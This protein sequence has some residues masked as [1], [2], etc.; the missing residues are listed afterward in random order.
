MWI[1]VL[2]EE[3]KTLSTENYRVEYLFSLDAT[4]DLFLMQNID[5]SCFEM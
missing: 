1:D 2:A 4:L 3:M 5:Y